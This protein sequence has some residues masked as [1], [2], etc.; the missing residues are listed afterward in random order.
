[1]L[2]VLNQTLYLTG[3]CSLPSSLNL[4]LSKWKTQY[5]S[6]VQVAQVAQSAQCCLHVTCMIYGYNLLRW[7]SDICGSGPAIGA[8]LVGK[9]KKNCMFNWAQLS[10]WGVGSDTTYL[11]RPH[12]HHR[13]EVNNCW[14]QKGSLQP[15]PDTA[16]ISNRG[17]PLHDSPLRVQINY[18]RKRSLLA[19][20]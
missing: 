1:M 12:F 9:K 15:P 16:C 13:Q 17:L 5:F 10:Y 20:R 11:E 14:K 2:Q 18:K 8:A 3:F 19:S 4:I 6:W 7:K